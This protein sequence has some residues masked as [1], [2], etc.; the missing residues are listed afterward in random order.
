MVSAKRKVQTKIKHQILEKY[1]GAWTGIILSGV[2]KYRFGNTV[3]KVKFVYVDLFSCTGYYDSDTAQPMSLNGP[4]VKGSPLI[5]IDCLKKAV[6]LGHDYKVDVSYNCIFIE[7]TKP[8]FEELISKL[9]DYKPIRPGTL[10]NTDDFESLKDQD[11][12]VIQGDCL[13]YTDRIIDYIS[14]EHTW[15]F[16]FIDPYGPKSIPIHMVKR[17]INAKKVDSM[18]NFPILNVHRKGVT[19]QGG[20]IKT[21][22]SGEKQILENI[23]NVFGNQKWRTIAN[24][25]ISLPPS[26]IRTNRIDDSLGKYYYNC[27]LEKCQTSYIKRIPIKFP[28]KNRIIFDLLLAT[29]N[30][31]GAFVMNNILREAEIDQFYH[32]ERAKIFNAQRQENTNNQLLI[33][34]AEIIIK[35]P[36]SVVKLS[37]SKYSGEEVSEWLIKE[38]KGE[39]LTIDNIYKRSVNTT[40]TISE[41]H[42]GLRYLKNKSKATYI[43]LNDIKNRVVFV[44]NNI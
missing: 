34:P 18:I 3:P 36:D 26:P 12:A 9:E 17:Y 11:I 23:D 22:N 35:N 1:L 21:R 16:V 38:F 14:S 40:F 37:P 20:G 2:K 32:A 10:I 33:F 39:S 15:T 7:E 43:S 28:D 41:I 30:Y 31:N 24:Q 44:T 8:N 19:S 29:K 27:L 42:K 25:Y 13:D 5:G 6:Q 4:V